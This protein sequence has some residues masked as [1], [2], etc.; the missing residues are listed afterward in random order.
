MDLEWRAALALL[1]DLVLRRRPLKVTLQLQSA[2]LRRHAVVLGRGIFL[3]LC[4][5]F[6]SWTNLSIFFHFLVLA[7]KSKCTDLHGMLAPLYTLL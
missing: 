5:I 7:H 2:L 4:S 3:C 1:A 6:I